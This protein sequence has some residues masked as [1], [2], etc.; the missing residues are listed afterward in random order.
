MIHSTVN[1]KIA[2]I[3]YNVQLSHLH[4]CVVMIKQLKYLQIHLSFQYSIEKRF[5]QWF[6]CLRL[7][8]HLFIAATCASKMILYCICIVD[9]YC[10]HFQ[11]SSRLFIV[12]I[13]GMIF[14]LR[15]LSAMMQWWCET[16]SS[17]TVAWSGTQ[18]RWLETLTRSSERERE[19]LR[20]REE[21]NVMLEWMGMNEWMCLLL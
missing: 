16:K 21:W 13:I 19:R 18:L 10:L 12:I 20:E 9:N 11:F 17:S 8:L 6:V 5:D 3:L 14:L 4:R 1:K 2:Q 15:L 7:H